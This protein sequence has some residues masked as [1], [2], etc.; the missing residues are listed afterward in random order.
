[1]AVEGTVSFVLKTPSWFASFALT[2]EGFVPEVRLV[3]VQPPGVVAVN[4][5]ADADGTAAAAIPATAAARASTAETVLP[6]VKCR[7]VRDPL[8]QLVDA[9][10]FVNRLPATSDA[11]RIS[12]ARGT[13]RTHQR[14]PMN[15][16]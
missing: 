12:T 5:P 8:C 16:P 2:T 14:V 3:K 11:P 15:Y 13:T 9:R 6:G 7:T 1:M 10:A 4:V